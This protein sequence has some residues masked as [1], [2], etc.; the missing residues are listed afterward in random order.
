MDAL[1]FIKKIDWS[2]LK[3]QKKCLIASIEYFHLHKVPEIPDG[4]E[5][6][7]NLID[8]LQDFAVDEAQIADE[9]EVFDLHPDGEEEKVNQ[10]F[11]RESADNIFM[12]LTE[13]EF[14][15]IDID[16]E[17]STE[18]IESIMA[19][20]KH[21]AAIKVLIKNQILEDMGSRPAA[22]KYDDNSI[23]VYDADMRTDYEFVAT[24]YC[25]EIWK[26]EQTRI[27]WVCKNCGGHN[28][29][30]K[31]WVDLN[32]NQIVGN[33]SDGEDQDNYCPD[34]DGHHGVEQK[35]IQGI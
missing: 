30:T 19:D 25:R 17:M 11:A 16:G 33:V 4:L 9:N 6:I 24:N 3:E 27:A 23:P 12:E 29:Q 13:S 21:I 20:D 1:E 7:L 14:F 8:A 18:F 28:V 34:C 35:E 31:Y 2:L 22:F 15:H 10:K 32:T 5:G 26:S